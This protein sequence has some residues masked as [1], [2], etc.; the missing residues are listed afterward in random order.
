MYTPILV[1]LR[2]EI[3]GKK[4]LI[5]IN[6]ALIAESNLT[7]L[8]NNNTLII[9]VDKETQKQ[10]LLSRE[11]TIEQINRRLNSQLNYTQKKKA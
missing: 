3:Y 5:I 11:L 6:A 7:F 2:K 1:R 10:R 4:G 9:K 8:S